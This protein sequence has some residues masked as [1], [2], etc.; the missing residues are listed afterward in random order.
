MS[1]YNEIEKLR[2]LINF[3]NIT[4]YKIDRK[5]FHE[6]YKMKN[7]SRVTRNEI[8]KIMMNIIK[9]PYED[10]LKYL[11]SIGYSTEHSLYILILFKSMWKEE[12]SLADESVIF[13]IGEFFEQSFRKT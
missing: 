8:S 13:K 5:E 3:N 12:L 9:D 11:H 6:W 10:Q 4:G 2:K 1:Y 7:R